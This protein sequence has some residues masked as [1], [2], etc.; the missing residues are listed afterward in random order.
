MDVNIKK[1]ICIVRVRCERLRIKKNALAPLPPHGFAPGTYLYIIVYLIYYAVY[2]Y[3]CSFS[4][5]I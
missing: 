5:D 1:S 3:P 2:I 4:L